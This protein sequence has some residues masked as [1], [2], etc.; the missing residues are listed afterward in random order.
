[1]TDFQRGPIWDT[2]RKDS[3]ARSVRKSLVD[4]AKCLLL[5]DKGKALEIQPVDALSLQFV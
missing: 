5:V 1:M 3:D 4:V 2:F